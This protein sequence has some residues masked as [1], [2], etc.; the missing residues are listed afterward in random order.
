MRYLHS[1]RTEIKTN[2]A[3]NIYVESNA[4]EIKS[5]IGKQ[6][7]NDDIL[8]YRVRYEYRD[9]SAS[10]SYIDSQNLHQLAL[11]FE[12]IDRGDAWSHSYLIEPGVYTDFNTI[13]TDDI[14]LAARYTA[15]YHEPEAWSYLIGI[16]AGRQFGKPQF[17]PIIGAIYKPNNKLIVSIAFP[18]TAF[19]YQ[20]KPKWSTYSFLRPIGGQW[21]IEGTNAQAGQKFNPTGSVD[22]VITGYHF[23]AGIEHEFSRK[24]WVGLEL[25][26][27]LNQTYKFKDQGSNELK[28]DV[29]N[30]VAASVSAKWKI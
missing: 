26:S 4:V 14:G 13:N 21:N 28:T 1:G 7:F 18:V 24:F 22:F 30:R 27:L 8:L 11:A 15:L 19:R 23:A 3:E 16:G 10:H 29:G 9:I 20:F 2:Q 5:F 17:Y 12:Y 6:Q 25:G